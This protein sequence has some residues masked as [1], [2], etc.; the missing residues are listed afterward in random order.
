MKLDPIAKVDLYKYLGKWYEIARFDSWFEHNC[1]NVTA[2]YFLN[3]KGYITVVNTC[4][5]NSPDGEKKQAIGY[6]KVASRV[7]NSKL[8][9]TFL[10]RWLRFFDLLFRAKYWILKLEPD[11]SI[12]LVGEPRRKYLWILSRTPEISKSQYDE[13]VAAAAEMGFDIKK[14]H[15]TMQ[16]W[17]D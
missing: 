1:C 7:K 6:A 16:Q 17:P 2:E 14:L 3:T 4:Y 9:V 15:K 5:I 8:A 12:A 10:P 11:Y 13:Y